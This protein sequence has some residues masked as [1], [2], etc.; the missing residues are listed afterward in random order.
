[1]KGGENVILKD[2]GAF[3][4]LDNLIIRKDQI[5]ILVLNRLNIELSLINNEPFC[6]FSGTNDQCKEVYDK[7]TSF[8]KLI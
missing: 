4:K 5:S 1:M 7:I 6:I 3:I 8:L 2:L